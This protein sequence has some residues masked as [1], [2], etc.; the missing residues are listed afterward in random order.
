[1]YGSVRGATSNGRP[2]R[3]NLYAMRKT[4]D[5]ELLLSLYRKM[6]ATEVFVQ[7]LQKSFPF[8]GFLKKKI[9]SH[10]DFRLSKCSGVL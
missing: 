8:L 1:M 5:W 6:R 9:A 2:Y 7:F 10:C 3:D 4:V